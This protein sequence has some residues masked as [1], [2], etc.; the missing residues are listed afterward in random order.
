MGSQDSS[1][2]S[3]PVDA[4]TR[5]DTYNK[6]TQAIQG[7]RSNYGGTGYKAPTYERLGEGDYAAVRSG[8]EAPIDRAKSVDMEAS[9]QA[10]S[11]RGIYTSLNALRA[12]NDVSER[13]APQYA[14]VGAAVTNLKAGDIAGANTAKMENANR[15]YEAS[16]RPADYKAGLW[17]GTGG[18]V[19]SGGSGG[20]SI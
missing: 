18:V 20:W 13:Y 2:Q 15:E 14:G 9:N 1:S 10:M 4:A 3:A 7:D 11:D 17:N 16:W 12:N 6:G 5:L 8:L 19:S